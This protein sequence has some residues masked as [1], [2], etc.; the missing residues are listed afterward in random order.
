MSRYEEDDEDCKTT[1]EEEC[2]MKF[3]KI[4]MAMIIFKVE[5]EEF[6]EDRALPIFNNFDQIIFFKF[7]ESIYEKYS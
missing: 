3:N 6:V 5:S 7:V 2:R 4:C 1:E